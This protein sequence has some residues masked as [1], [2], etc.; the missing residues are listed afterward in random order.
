MMNA[1]SESEAGASF[2][3]VAQGEEWELVDPWE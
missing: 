2:G 1:E 3:V